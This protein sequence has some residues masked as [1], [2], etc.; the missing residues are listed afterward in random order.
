MFLSYILKTIKMENQ[1]ISSRFV[2]LHKIGSGSFGQIFEC[3]RLKDKKKF[4]AKLEPHRTRFPQLIFEARIYSALSGSPNVGKIR[5]YGL[6]SPNNVM[7]MDLYGK[8]LESLHVSINRMSLKTV[9]MIVDQML[10][11]IEWVHEKG[12]IH[13]DIKPDNFMF[14]RD[15]KENQLF[16]IDFGLSKRYR[17]YKS[18]EH[19]KFT[20]GKSL[21]GTARYCSV[22]ALRGCEQSRRDDMEAL[23]FVWIY[24]LKGVLPWMNLQA[25]GKKQKYEVICEC[26]ARTSFETL[27]E[28]LPREFVD[29][30]KSVRKLAFEER[31]PYEEYRRMFRELFTSLGFVYDYMFDWKK[32]G[33]HKKPNLPL[34][35][36]RVSLSPGDLLGSKKPNMPAR[37]LA[38]FRCSSGTNLIQQQDS[39]R[40]NALSSMRGED[41]DQSDTFLQV[42]D[43]GSSS[44]SA[45][46]LNISG[47]PLKSSSSS[48][49]SVSTSSSSVNSSTSSGSSPGDS[50][51][52]SSSSSTSSGSGGGLL[53]VFT[54]HNQQVKVGES[55]SDLTESQSIEQ[56]NQV[57]EAE[58]SQEQPTIHE[59]KSM[60]A[61]ATQ[62]DTKKLVP[63]LKVRVEQLQQP[64]TKFGNLTPRA[65]KNAR[66]LN[67]PGHMSI[68]SWMSH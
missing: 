46:H 8:S 33:E 6:E 24:L 60:S 27:C 18:L 11:S 67:R 34:P 56:L 12:F 38:M 57:A 41:D 3:T 59:M 40:V 47:L 30:F 13:R 1:V 28:G 15:E 35:A 25:I 53:G 62:Q 51:T 52:Y 65:R 54:Q 21:T 29:Y 63:E 49:S 48:G 50:S 22:N 2:L 66:P 16:I 61:L 37:N 45:W 5:W 39:T 7:V 4:A 31:P 10:T 26:K 14:G 42:Y 68:P 23:G 55:S 19:I 44:S 32:D 58:P 17:D 36:K 9:L 43:E 20:T 64:S